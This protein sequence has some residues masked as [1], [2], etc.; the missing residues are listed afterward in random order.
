MLPTQVLVLTVHAA[1]M[2]YTMQNMNVLETLL[3][4]H[5]LG[6]VVGLATAAMT[7]GVMEAAALL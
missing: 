4:A 2:F 5:A 3:Q 6:G 1:V 7:K